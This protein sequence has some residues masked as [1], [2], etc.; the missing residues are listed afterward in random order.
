VLFLITQAV[1]VPV[2]VVLLYVSCV[3]TLILYLFSLRCV[4]R[5]E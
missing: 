4:I 1:L 2:P 3:S 5:L